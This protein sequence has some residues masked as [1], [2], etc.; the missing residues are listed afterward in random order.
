MSCSGPCQQ[1]KKPCPCPQ[2]C[3]LKQVEEVKTSRDLL[4]VC[5]VVLGA[6]V[7]AVILAP[8]FVGYVI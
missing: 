8:M 6:W 5:S 3:Q 1:G 7:T 2:S 4:I